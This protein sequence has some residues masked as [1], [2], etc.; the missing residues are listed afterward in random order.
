[1]SPFKNLS[2]SWIRNLTSSAINTVLSSSSTASFRLPH[3][4]HK[5]SMRSFA[6]DSGSSTTILDRNS[7]NTYD[8]DCC[9]GQNILVPAWSVTV[10]VLPPMKQIDFKISAENNQNFTFAS[11]ILICQYSLILWHILA[12]SF[13]EN[14][15]PIPFCFSVRLIANAISLWTL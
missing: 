12:L 1:M 13:S 4:L 14:T 8:S 2:A 3:N 10:R 7:L 5:S 15:L 9:C 6:G 11:S